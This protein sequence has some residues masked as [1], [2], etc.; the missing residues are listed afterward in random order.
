MLNT[1]KGFSLATFVVLCRS[2][3]AA[4]PPDFNRDIRPILSGNC[5]ACHGPDRAKRKADLRLDTQAGALLDLGGR[6]AIVPGDPRRSEMYLRVTAADPDERMPPRKSGKSLSSGDVER[7]RSWIEAGAP[8]SE[9]WS[10]API[11]RPAV[12]GADDPAFVRNPIDRFILE[13]LRAEGLSPSA[14]ADRVTLLRRI[15]LDLTG[16]APSPDEVDAYLADPR[17]DAFER[18]VDRLLESAHHGERMAM[19]WLDLVRYADTTGYHGDNHRDVA[20]YRDYVIRAFA[21]NK[22]FD[23]FTLEQIAGDLL[24]GAGIEAKIA[25]GYNRMNMTTQEGGA[26]AM[27]YV[28]KYAADRVRNTSTVW[29]GATVGCAECHDHKYDPF[30]QREFYSFAAFFADVKEMAI[31][32]PGP[33]FLVPGVEDL[34]ALE[35]I[36]LAI[37]SLR[38]RLEATPPEIEAAFARWES[39]AVEEANAARP[40]LGPW[41]A[42]GPFGAESF[43]AAY[44]TAFSPEVGPPPRVYTGQDASFTPRPELADGAVH[45]LGGENSATY[46][47]RAIQAERSGPLSLSLGSDDAIKAWLNGKE[48]LARRVTRAAAPDQEK[49]TV[50][51]EAGENT[52]LLKIVNGSGAGGFYFKA[53]ESSLPAELLTVLRKPGTERSAEDRRILV[54]HYRAT[55]PELAPIRDEIALREKEKAA[56]LKQ[57][58]TTMVSMSVEPRVVRV[59]RRGDWMDTSGDVVEP[60]VPGFLPRLSGESRDRLALARWLVSPE[61]PLPARALANRLWKLFF[62]AGLARTLDDLGS[63]GARPTHPELLDWLS[64]ELLERRWDVRHLVRLMVLSGT[65]R[66]SSRSSPEVRERDPYNHLLGRQGRFRLE[67]EAVRDN[68]LRASGLLSLDVGGPSVRPYQPGGYWTHLNFPRREYQNSRGRDLYRRGLYTYWQRTF[69]HPS[70]LAFDAPSR[71]ECT[72]ERAR[73]NTPLQAL[74]LLTDPMYVEAARVLAERALR[75]GGS[76]DLERLRWIHRRALSRAAEAREL[77]VLESLL[78]KHRAEYAA[79]PKAAADLLST[80]EWPLPKDLDPGEMAAWMSVARV[81]LNLHET[82]T[83]S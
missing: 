68:A 74:V 46:L 45:A 36:D 77:E 61:N 50:Q 21:E 80:G 13:R 20:P 5:F 1:L 8:W 52:I 35:K 66:Q 32:E 26:Q 54:E 34:A 23:T 76:S 41:I 28:A 69:L 73:S 67:A 81:V 75:E 29:L 64:S 48:V 3:P 82:I 42:A 27:E 25:S 24:P 49:V 40:R 44:A 9:H 37:A 33:G 56:R 47:S 72:V 18:R 62:G 39:A 17:P 65:Y 19:Y 30:T 15:H 53:L 83:R 71:E 10:Y 31:G 14:E 12:P 78:G 55:A 11:E 16:L 43:E 58:P 4:G 57:V 7:L 51:L 79:D 2:L 70:L 38:E 59:L 6:A 60:D 22:P 63:Q